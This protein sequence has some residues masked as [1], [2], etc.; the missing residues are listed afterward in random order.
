M[1]CLT[2]TISSRRHPLNLKLVMD[3][4]NPKFKKILICKPIQTITFVRSRLHVLMFSMQMRGHLYITNLRIKNNKAYCIDFQGTSIMQ[5]PCRLFR[6]CQMWIQVKRSHLKQSRFVIRT[7]ELFTFRPNY[8]RSLTLFFIHSL[9]FISLTIFSLTIYF[10][11]FT[12]LWNGVLFK[13]L[14]DVH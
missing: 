5:I 14:L 4:V 12:Y 10:I 11:H 3:R 2:V 8:C 9:Y 6:L 7:P 1:Q 13:F